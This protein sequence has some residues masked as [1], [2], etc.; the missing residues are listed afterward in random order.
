M[1]VATDQ[2]KLTGNAQI[3]LPQEDRISASARYRPQ[4]AER[5]AHRRGSVDTDRLF[6]V[7]GSP[8]RVVDV[9]DITGYLSLRALSASAGESKLQSN[10][11]EGSSG[12]AA[13]DAS[14]PKFNE[15]QREKAAVIEE[16][17]KAE[18]ERE[19][20]AAEQAERDKAAF[21]GR[22]RKPGAGRS[23]RE[24][25]AEGRGCQGTATEAARRARRNS[26]SR[27]RRT[28]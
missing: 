19:A 11:L 21:A 17:R 10:V 1:T 22:R 26:R 23:R 15:Q 3:D 27:R 18:E 14:L 16:Q 5:G 6:G 20:V 25:K 8:G 2:A 24:A 4:S 13:G 7:L 12:C 9:T 28:R